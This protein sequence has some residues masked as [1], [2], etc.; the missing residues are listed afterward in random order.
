[1][2]STD[3]PANGTLDAAGGDNRANRAQ[4]ALQCPERMA[5]FSLEKGDLPDDNYH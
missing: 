4:T 3:R 1:M 5:K 2:R